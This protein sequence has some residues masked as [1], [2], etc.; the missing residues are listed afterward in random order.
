MRAAAYCHTRDATKRCQFSEL[1][2]LCCIACMTICCSVHKSALTYKEII[3]SI[4][5]NQ[6]VL[7]ICICL[8]FCTESET[9]AHVGLRD[10]GLVFRAP[11]CIILWFCVA[12]QFV[13]FFLILFCIR[14]F[15]CFVCQLQPANLYSVISH[16]PCCASGFRYW[17]PP[18]LCKILIRY[19]QKVNWNVTASGVWHISRWLHGLLQK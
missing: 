14:L 19:L 18:G 10:G 2:P 11:L 8:I 7:C 9:Y 6:W 12:S 3:F 16:F 13:K 17:R 15:L 4:F 1:T 5:S